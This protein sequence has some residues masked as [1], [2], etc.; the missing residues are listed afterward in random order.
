MAPSRKDSHME[1]VAV[2]PYCDVPSV[3][4]QLDEGVRNKHHGLALGRNVRDDEVHKPDFVLEL[5]HISRC[6]GR[7]YPI[8]CGY[9]GSFYVFTR[10]RVSELTRVAMFAKVFHTRIFLF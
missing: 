3:P 9:E 8:L 6:A 5:L 10:E 4:R 1:K 7:R 2:P